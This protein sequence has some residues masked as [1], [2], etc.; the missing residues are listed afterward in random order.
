MKRTAIASL[1]IISLTA[2]TALS[3]NM[4]A[5]VIS[6]Q[7]VAEDARGMTAQNTVILLAAIAVA[8][9]ILSASSGGTAAPVASD[10]RLKTDIKRVG[11]AANGLPLYTYRYKGHPER[12][13]GVMAQDVQRVAPHA[14][15]EFSDGYLAVDYDALGL[16]LTRVD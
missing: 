9:A 2:T 15:H 7:S 8:L 12:F 16:S 11:T 3:G 10:S 6:S 14:V 5:P 13:K 1:L 4:K